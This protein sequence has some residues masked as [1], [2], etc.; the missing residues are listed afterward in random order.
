L[1]QK[2]VD[3]IAWDP[4][5]RRVGHAKTHV[6]R[7][8]WVFVVVAIGDRGVGDAIED[9]YSKHNHRS[10]V[11]PAEIPEDVWL[12]SSHLLNTVAKSEDEIK[13]VDD[14]LIY[15]VRMTHLCAPNTH[16]IATV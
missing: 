6:L 11:L 14:T 13:V 4:D 5:H 9:E 3:S 2:V 16:P 12:V 10:K 7:P 8:L 15:F 1:S